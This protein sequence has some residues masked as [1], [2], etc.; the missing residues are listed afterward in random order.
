MSYIQQF[1]VFIRFALRRS[2]FRDKAGSA[3]IVMGLALPMLIGASALA[4]DMSN[5]YLTKN[6]L[7]IAA[8]AGALAGANAPLDATATPITVQ[9]LVSQNIPTSFGKVQN[10]GDVELGVYESTTKTFTPTNTAPNAVRVT[11]HRDNATG[12]PLPTYFG[13]V[14][15]QNFIQIQAQ[16]VATG[17]IQPCFL[18]LDPSAT[19]AFDLTGNAGMGADN[20][21]VFVN[22]S[23]SLAASATV[24]ATAKRFC[25][26]GGS[27]GLFS[28]NPKNCGVAPDPLEYLLD[29]TAGPCVTPPAPS[30]NVILYP[31]TY[32]SG[33]NYPSGNVTFAPGLYYFKGTQLN[34]TGSTNVVSTDATLFFDASSSLNVNT[35][36][37][38]NLSAPTSGTYK[39][40]AVY[41]SRS[42]PFSTVATLVGSGNYKLS[43][44]IYLPTATLKMASIGSTAQD[45]YVSE[46]IVKKLVLYGDSNWHSV[47][48]L[49]RQSRMTALAPALVL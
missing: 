19:K 21:D 7:Q 38:V 28:P 24:N 20:C 27:S 3:M 15:G 31:G 12:N 26:V 41:Q 22:S 17:V 6:K 37:L 46:V 2:L 8:D 5:A 25:F 1:S 29:P 39:G 44:A 14:F 30:G 16:A 11:T 18:V 33:L 23:N 40:I 36:G 9:D 47:I 42:S 48:D 45:A 13:R 32:C 49:S 34:L 43:G 35:T 4:I 10:A